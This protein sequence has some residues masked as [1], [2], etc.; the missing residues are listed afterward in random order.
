MPRTRADWTSRA[1]ASRLVW[2]SPSIARIVVAMVGVVVFTR[3]GATQTTDDR[4]A[5][6]QAALDYLEGFYEGDTAK[7]VRSIRPEVF[8][9]GFWRHNDSTR[10]APSEQMPWSEFLAYAKRVK[11]SNRPAPPN[12]PKEVVLLDVL[13]QTANA[14]VT[15]WWGTDY[16]LMGKFGGRW[17][18]THVLWQSPP[19]RAKGSS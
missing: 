13:D 8:K 17:M 12:A 3:A 9:L 5:V 14:K 2:L 11:A 10:Y 16:L 4:N 6:R 18:I 19:P 15:A 1:M 7:L